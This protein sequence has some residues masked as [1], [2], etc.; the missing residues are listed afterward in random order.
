MAQS[1]SLVIHFKS[2]AKRTIALADI[3]KITFDSLK[4]SVKQ[5]AKEEPAIVYP[6]PSTGNTTIGFTIAEPAHVQ[7][8]IVGAEGKTIR[9]LSK[10]NLGAGYHEILW[11][12]LGD[13]GKRVAAGTYLCEV[14]SKGKLQVS[15]MIVL[16]R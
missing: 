4:S 10:Q 5:V 12:G 1:D 16:S 11:D 9:T 8:T 13:D 3:R 15:K 7:I 14:R 2:G 6:N